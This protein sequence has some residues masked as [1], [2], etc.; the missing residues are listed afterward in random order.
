MKEHLIFINYVGI[1]WDN[2]NIYDFIFSLETEN[3]DGDGWDNYPASGAPEIPPE[4]LI[5]SV[6][7]IETAIKFDLVSDSELFAY[8]DAVDGVIAIGWENTDNYEVYP[9]KRIYFKFLEGKDTIHRIFIEK[10]IKI[11]TLLNTAKNET[12]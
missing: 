6:I 3:I 4:H 5:S 2:Q 10:E 12:N 1:G 8:W 9:E 11:T 7:R